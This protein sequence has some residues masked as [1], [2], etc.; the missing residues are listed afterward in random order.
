MAIISN[1][2]PINSKPC[3]GK[4]SRRKNRVRLI[5]CTGSSR[6]AARRCWN[7]LTNLD[8]PFPGVRRN[9]VQLNRHGASAVALLR[10]RG[11]P[12]RRGPF[13]NGIFVKIVRVGG[14][15]AD[16][17]CACTTPLTNL[18]VHF[19]LKDQAPD[20]KLGRTRD[21]P[22]GPLLVEHA[23]GSLRRG[24]RDAVRPRERFRQTRKLPVGRR[25]LVRPRHRRSR[26][27]SERTRGL[28][29]SPSPSGC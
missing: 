3:E 29:M 4:I 21:A 22:S 12:R 20:R 9:R 7:V 8:S 10:G 26:T 19:G 16:G 2:A 24:R 13:I 1:L 18:P 15:R 28:L 6:R 25:A 14:F 23:R 11:R 17:S 5:D 27:S